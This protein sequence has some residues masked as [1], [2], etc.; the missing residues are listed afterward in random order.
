M[1]STRKKAKSLQ[2]VKRVKK[3]DDKEEVDL[4]RK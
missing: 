3:L 2:K 4:N 1:Q